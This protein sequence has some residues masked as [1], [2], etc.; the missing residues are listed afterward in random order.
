MRLAGFVWRAACFPKRSCREGILSKKY[1]LNPLKILFTAFLL[2][3]PCLVAAHAATPDS[4]DR[5][6]SEWYELVL[7]NNLQ[8]RQEWMEQ[9]YDWMDPANFLSMD[10]PEMKAVSDEIV[11]GCSNG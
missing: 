3:Y 2:A 4:T 7:E 6:L 5:E 8:K 10:D 11:K 1:I 9:R